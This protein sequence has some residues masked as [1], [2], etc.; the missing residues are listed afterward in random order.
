MIPSH[1]K[2]HLNS[3]EIAITQL[4][5][6]RCVIEPR[7]SSLVP[8]DRPSSRLV[9][10]LL[11]LLPLVVSLVPVDSSSSL[12]SHPCPFLLHPSFIPLVFPSPSIP[13]PL[14]LRGV[15]IPS[16]QRRLNDFILPCLCLLL[17]MMCLVP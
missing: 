15:V 5:C 3:Q 11:V 4:D 17:L 14:I 2:R 10:A 8:S 9:F 13:A 7:V 1:T 6:I 16:P 12:H